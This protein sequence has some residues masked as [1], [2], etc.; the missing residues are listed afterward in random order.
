MNRFIQACVERSRTVLFLLAFLLLAGTLT[1]LTIP[2]ESAPDVKIPIIYISL[3]HEGISPEDAERLIIRPVEQKVRSIEGL[4][5]V[6]ATA[7]ENGGNVVLEFRA[8]FD[9]KKALDDVR[10]KVDEAKVDF[11]ADTDEPAVKEV[12]FSLFPVL[13]IN[14]AGDIPSRVLYRLAKELKDS[15]EEKVSAVLEVN[16]VGDREEAVEILVDPAKLERYGFSFADVVVLFKRNNVLISAGNLDIGRGRFPVKIPGLLT[17]VEDML[18]SPIGTSK[19]KVVKFSE[20]AEIRRTYKDPLGYARVGGKPSVS[21]EVSKRTGENIIQTIERV[22]KVVEE[23][24][25]IWPSSL[26]V[27]YSQDESK[28]IKDM[29]SDLEN[30]VIISLLLVFTVI[31]ASLGWRSGFLVGTAVPGSFLIGILVIALQGYT[32]N[33]VVLFGLIL[34]VGMLVDGAI[35]VAE[36]AD[37]KMVEGLGAREA[38]IQGAQRMAWPVITTTLTIIAAFMPLLFWPGIVGQFMK[39]LPI[40]LVAT[41]T[42]SIAMA[43]IFLPALGSLFGKKVSTFKDKKKH[44]ISATEKGDL[45][46]VKGYIGSYLKVLNKA[47]DH[48]GWVLLGVTGLLV[49]VIVI[50]KIYGKGAEFFPTI[51]PNTAVVQVRARGSLSVDERDALV[52]AVE[53]RLLPMKEFKTVY[54][55]TTIGAASNKRSKD[56]F[57][58][59]VGLISLE[60]VD[61]QER[62]KAREILDDVR[63]RVQDIPGIMVSIDEDKPGPPTGKPIFLQLSATQNELLLPAFKRILKYVHTVEGLQSFEDNG[64]IP[65]LE[66][67]INVN[68]AEAARYGADVLLVGSFIRF[69]TNGQLV[70]KFRPDDSRDEI[71]ILVR[72]LPEYR[73][74]TQLQNVMI[75]TAVGV[76]PLSLFAQQKLRPKIDT[77][78]RSDGYRVYR[79]KADTKPGYLGPEKVNEIQNWLDENQKDSRVHVKFKGQD[80][81]QQ[82]TGAFLM[83][84][85]GV[86]L[87]LITIMLVTQFNSF[88]SAGL[89]LSAVVLS[90][91]GVLIGLLIMGRPFN[92][93]MGGIGVIALGGIIVSN[94]IILIDTFDRLKN[95]SKDIR[96]VILRTCA[97]RIRPVLLT[98]ITCVLG[99]LPTALKLTIDLLHLEFS[100]DAPASQWWVDLSLAIVSGVIFAAALTLFVT[101]C[102]LMARENFVARKLSKR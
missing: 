53:Q 29:L 32:I 60:F 24:Q 72:Y 4:K 80:E 17:G 73:N 71:D 25:K 9:S 6:R 78:N 82:E 11:P 54:T 68:R 56:V 8:G 62:R 65:G 55:N 35:I 79:I 43:L 1:Y 14:L 93:V 40:T 74:L 36:Y 12:N 41:L 91:I 34:S 38:F 76:V 61:W 100:Y 96:D 47:L 101:P 75:K 102:A 23:E 69:I 31:V 3:F 13:V 70:D 49:T 33:I 90:T 18:N 30:N 22:Q 37:R 94:N 64:P 58:D 99:L 7:F 2:K 86:A 42:A 85:F 97:Q 89:V 98:K 48:P 83:K 77:I 27:S 19:G 26:T 63:K 46:K 57:D 28:R 84:A 21:L 92:I 39:F 5:E 45:T 20:I 16:V 81:E 59:T 87:F 88:F 51:E 15:I 66:W 95:E 50:F 44:T 52:R 10:N 67:V